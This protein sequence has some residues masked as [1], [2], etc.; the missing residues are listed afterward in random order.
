MGT[1]TPEQLATEAPGAR[2]WFQLYLWKDRVASAELV[3][4]A[5]D[6]GC[7]TLV[8]T[9]DTPVGGLRLR[10]QRN[11]MT[12]PPSLT[13]RTFLDGIRHPNW[14]INFLTTDPLEFASLTHF[15]GT[16]ADLAAIMF[17]PRASFDDVAWLRSVW[18][19]SLVVKGVQV[20][21]DAERAVAAGADAIVVSN[22]GG[23]QLDR[24]PTPLEQL[25]PVRER[26]GDRVQV[27]L[28]GGVRSG[29][30]IAAAVG[31]GADGVFVG[32]AYLYGLMAGGGRG[33]AR[34]LEI[35]HAE[36]VNAMQLLG[37]RKVEELRKE[38]VRLRSDR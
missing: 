31:L 8:L 38:R 2:R 18:R 19:G 34:A 24:A 1:T 6:A 30:D 33:V 15:A 3:R 11:G 27:Y 4:R 20:A 10:D 35:L 26:V 21:D 16:A 28:D 22:H 23:R 14:W 37:V 5:Q 25:A 9:V 13:A 17:D 29:A 7:D 12:L 32:R 36:F